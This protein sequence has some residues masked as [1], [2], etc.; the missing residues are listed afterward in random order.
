MAIFGVFEILQNSVVCFAQI[1]SVV[2]G[3]AK[4]H[5]HFDKRLGLKSSDSTLSETVT[6]N[7]L[8]LNFLL[9]EK[10]T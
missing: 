8:S 4:V 6:N 9:F 3:S 10:A 2:R 7:I 5:V 1:L